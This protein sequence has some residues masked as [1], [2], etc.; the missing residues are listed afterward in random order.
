MP[1]GPPHESDK[2]APSEFYL[3]VAPGSEALASGMC[4][5]IVCSEDGALNLTDGSGQIRESIPVFKGF[6]PYRATVINNPTAGSAPG[7]VVAIY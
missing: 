4:R 5:G 6:N 1:S 7:T 2:T 3:T